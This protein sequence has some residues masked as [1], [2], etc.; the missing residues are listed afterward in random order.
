MAEF[1]LKNIYFEF[2]GQVKQKI[3][4]TVIGTKF[5]PTYAC[6]FMDDVEI[7]FLETQSLQPLFW[8]RYIDD[9]FF[10]WTHGEG[11]IQLFLTDLKNYNLILNL[12]MSLIK[13]TSF[14][15]LK[16]SVCDDKLT[17]DLHV[18]PTDR[19][20]YLHYTLEHPNHTKWSFKYSQTLR[21]SKICS[22]KNDFEKHLE[23][24]KSW[25]WVRG[26]PDNLMKKEVGNVCF[27]KSTGSKSKSQESESVPLVLTFHPKFK[28]IGELL[29][30]Q[31]HI[32][33]TDQETKNVF[34]PG[35]MATFC[36]AGKLSSYLVRAK[37]YP[38][39]RIVGSHK[40]RSKR[41]EAC[42]NVQ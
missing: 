18:K 33:Y 4:G 34:T 17:T 25:F 22:Y 27:T 16:V 38:I 26:Y 36:S 20:L 21:I 10:I 42:L 8:F 35:L 41:C 1:G 5:A 29:N 6:I 2:N 30:K 7:K 9:V 24:M 28:S 11:K 15:D 39:E 19:H 13:N 37:L 31:L 40:C 14:L 3:C 12:H 23:Q 32:L